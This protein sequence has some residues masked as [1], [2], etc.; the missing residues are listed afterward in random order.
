MYYDYKEKFNLLCCFDNFTLFRTQKLKE[1][2]SRIKMPKYPASEL[3]K[4]KQ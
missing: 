2:D 3:F 1:L 4:L